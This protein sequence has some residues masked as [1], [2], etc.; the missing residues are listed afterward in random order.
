M[1]TET[2]RPDVTAQLGFY[3][4]RLIDTGGDTF[5]VGKGTGDR[6]HQHRGRD[7][8]PA[9]YEER[10]VQWGLTE[11]AALRLEAALIAVLDPPL[12][13]VAGHGQADCDLRTDTLQAR[14]GAA[15]FDVSGIPDGI[16]IVQVRGGD[17]YPHPGAVPC[18]HP[19]FE[20]IAVQGEDAI[21][22]R[23]QG[24]WVTSA[25]TA[26][27]VRQIAVA[28]GSNVIRRVYDVDAPRRVTHAQNGELYVVASQ[29]SKRHGQPQPRW[30]FMKIGPAAA[31]SPIVGTRLV[32]PG[33][34]K[35]PIKN[36]SPFNLS[37]A[38]REKAA[39]MH[40]VLSVAS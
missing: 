30:R 37:W 31:V 36:Q 16:L 12:N 6:V 32:F 14:L 26:H 25:A 5:Y 35:D 9:S 27:R 18:H 39:G 20:D 19:S 4:Y 22:R 40:P 3:V 24:D 34:V 10:I 2:L 11:D 1:L 29:K 23:V 8:F 38:L 17:Y 33:G 7:R 13:R 21:M 15:T 28:D